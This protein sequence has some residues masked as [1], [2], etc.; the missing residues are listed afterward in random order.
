MFNKEP[1][2]CLSAESVFKGRLKLKHPKSK[3]QLPGFL[4][5]FLFLR[6]KSHE[7]LPPS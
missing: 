6:K 7:M 2:V 3:I 5:I 4:K 1:G